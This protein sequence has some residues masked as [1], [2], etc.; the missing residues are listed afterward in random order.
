MPLIVDLDER[1]RGWC[2][3]LVAKIRLADGKVVT[4]EIEDHGAAAA[5]L[6]YDVARRT[7]IVIRQVRA[8][9]LYAGKAGM[10]EPIAGLIDPGE[11]AIDTA[12]RE[13]LE[14]AGVRV[15]DI[16]PLAT[17]WTMPGL[18]TERMTFFLAQYDDGDRTGT[19]GG[20]DDEA[21]EVIEIGLG[22]LAALIEQGDAVDLKMFT[23]LQ[24]LRTRRPELFTPA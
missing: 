21:I 18:S 4:R 7:A 9:V 13:A 11:E 2:R 1:Y 3:I 6:P 24:A 8:P 12:R 23:L 10:I 17:F 5:I 19:G 16:E 22:A 15:H 14:E 20:V